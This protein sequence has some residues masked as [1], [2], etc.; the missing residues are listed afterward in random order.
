MLQPAGCCSL[1][2]KLALTAG[3]SEAALAK[4]LCC[5][6]LFHRRRLSTAVILSCFLPRED[7]V[8]RD[9]TE[10]WLLRVSSQSWCEIPLPLWLP[11][12]CLMR[13]MLQL[14]SR[15]EISHLCFCPALYRA[16]ELNFPLKAYCS[17]GAGWGQAC[18][19][20]ECSPVAEGEA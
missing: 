10:V 1:P 4:G 17:S 2:Q 7:V 3:A 14:V 15:K 6:L 16:E 12:P 20:A 8:S 18:S 5:R 9:E 19:E 11:F 13:G